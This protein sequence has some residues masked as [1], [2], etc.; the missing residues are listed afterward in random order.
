MGGEDM[1]TL[2][3]RGV[4]VCERGRNELKKNEKVAVYR[5]VS[6]S[7]RSLS[8]MVKMLSEYRKQQEGRS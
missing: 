1:Q 6:I 3:S 7:A 8:I 4:C 5:L 2:V